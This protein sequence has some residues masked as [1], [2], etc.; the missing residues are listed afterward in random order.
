MPEEFHAMR[1][2]LEHPEDISVPQDPAWYVRGLLPS[3]NPARP[4]QVVLTQTGDTGMNAAAD[5][6]TNLSRSFPTV[7]CLLM[8]GIAAGVPDVLVPQRHVRLGDIVVPTWGIVDYGHVIVQGGRVELRQPFP[9]PWQLLRRVANQL[10]AA[11]LAGTRPWEQWLDT[12]RSPHLAGYG[13]PAD[14]TDVLA[15]PTPGARPLQHPPGIHSGHRAGLP[16]VHYGLVGS[17]N[18]S[19]RDAQVRDQ[20]AAE[21]NLRAF[22]MEGA[23]VGTSAFLNDRHWFMVRGISDYADRG[24]GPVWRNYASLA[25]AAYVRALLGACQPINTKPG[26]LD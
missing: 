5:A 19:L 7:D 13:R 10:Q 17:A 20:L 14:D 6:A 18:V 22:E 11:E 9:R 3:R 25:A 16:K 2:L 26:R 8:V 4:H 1:M 12:S 15:A 23:G 21:Y 24:F